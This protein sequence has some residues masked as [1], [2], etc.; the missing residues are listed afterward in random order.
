MAGIADQGRVSLDANGRPAIIRGVARD[1]T[2]R[3]KADEELAQWQRRY[4]AAVRAS[5]QILYDWA[6][7]TNR[8]VWAGNVAGILGYEPE[9]LGDLGHWIEQ[10]T[11]S[12]ER[13]V[14][15]EGVGTG[16]S[17]WSPE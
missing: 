16:R 2:E 13:R 12:E 1:I 10:L 6:P 3:R 7:R 11:H 15:Q 14:G 5:G 17:R 4:E 8:I 9:E